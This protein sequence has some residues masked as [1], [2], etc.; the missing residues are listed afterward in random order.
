[1]KLAI[2]CGMVLI[3][4]GILSLAYFASPVR[5]MLLQSVDP[6]SMDRLVPILGGIALISGI[7]L[8]VAVRPR[9][10]KSDL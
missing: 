6:H 10:K 8:L 3:G 4:L 7:A 1:M 9:K 2:V 5:Y